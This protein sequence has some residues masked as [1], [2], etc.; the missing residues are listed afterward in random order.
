MI[1]GISKSSDI[2]KSLKQLALERILSYS[3][4]GYRGKYSRI[5]D[6]KRKLTCFPEHDVIEER[7]EKESGKI[8]TQIDLQDIFCVEFVLIVP[9][10]SLLRILKR[11]VHKIIGESGSNLTLIR[12]NRRIVRPISIGRAIQF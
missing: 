9:G 1:L 11:R 7:S 6:K 12:E 2:G 8:L 10:T 3:A 4:K 5:W